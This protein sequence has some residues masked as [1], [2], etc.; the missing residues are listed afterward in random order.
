ML[1]HAEEILHQA[2][3][4]HEPLHVGGRLEAPHLALALPRR[5]VGDVGEPGVIM[6]RGAATLSAIVSDKGPRKTNYPFWGVEAP[7]WQGARREP[8]GSIRPAS[9][10]ADGLHRW[11]KMGSYP[12]AGPRARRQRTVT[13]TSC[14]VVNLS[15]LAV[16]LST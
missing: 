14:S 11:P 9:N 8:T 16:A 12:C 2:V 7:A 6:M 5:L 3:H 13:V 10:A 15:S 4:G 1:A